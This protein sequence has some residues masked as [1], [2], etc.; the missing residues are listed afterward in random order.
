MKFK[1]YYRTLGAERDAEPDEIKLS[2]RRL[3][4]KFH[5]DVNDGLD[6]EERF[7]QGGSESLRGAEGP[8]EASGLRPLRRRLEGG[9]GL[10]PR[11]T[12]SRESISPVAGS[13]ASASSAISSN[14]S[15][16]AAGTAVQAA[17]TLI[18]A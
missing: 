11:P 16:A 15:S 13:P 9:A 8:G 3:A 14:R 2:Y 7:N 18:C 17:D 10:P 6:A 12:G 4:R 1:D 5:P